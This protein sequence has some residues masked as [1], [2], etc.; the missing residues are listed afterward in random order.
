MILHI[1]KEDDKPV[2]FKSGKP[3]IFFD[4]DGT[5]A[6]FRSMNQEYKDSNGNPK[7]FHPRDLY[8]PGYFRN[9]AVHKSICESFRILKANPDFEVAVLTSVLYDSPYAVNDKRDWVKEHI[10]DDVTVIMTP[11]G[12]VK[13]DFIETTGPVILVDDFSRNLFEWEKES[14][15]SFGIKCRNDINGTHGTWKGYSVSTKDNPET[16]ALK[17]IRVTKDIEK[18]LGNNNI[19]FQGFSRNS[20]DLRDERS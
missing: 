10:G 18:L 6:E 7:F 2:C 8:D 20:G 16:I 19:E 15:L 1:L 9:L 13:R 5:C 14:P 4:L 12:K 11:C 17:I 3:V